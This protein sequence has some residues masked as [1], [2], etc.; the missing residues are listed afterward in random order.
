MFREF[1]DS[2]F[3]GFSF[4]YSSKDARINHATVLLAWYC[5]PPKGTKKILELGTGSG[6]IAIY[7]AKKYDVEVTAIDIDEELI[8]IARKNAQTNGVADKV[9]F[10]HLSSAMASRKFLAGSFD[11]VVSNPPHFAH[12]GIESPFQRRNASRRMTVEGIKE[13]A[14]TTGRLLKNGGAFFF[15]LHPR[16]ITRWLKAFEMNGLGI[17]G[18]RF[19][20]GTEHKQSQ[21]VLIKGRKSSTSEV[22]VEPPIIL[23]KGRS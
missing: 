1:D 20:F 22:V 17:H 8:R 18:L 3:D 10:M 13:F 23:R 21:L 5:D 12:K 19:V 16:D 4:D 11:V 14:Q 6:A 15:I 2:V 7:L 9:N